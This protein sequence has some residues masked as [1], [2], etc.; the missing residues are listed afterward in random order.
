MEKLNVLCE[1]CNVGKLVVINFYKIGGHSIGCDVC[2]NRFSASQTAYNALVTESNH[3]DAEND[4]DVMNDSGYWSFVTE[5]KK[6][7]DLDDYTKDMNKIHTI[8]ENLERTYYHLDGQFFRF[9]TYH[10]GATTMH[11][12]KPNGIEEFSNLIKHFFTFKSNPLYTKQTQI[13]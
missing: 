12:L 5:Y 11:H 8:K 10:D 6:G 7:F 9:A 13:L 2:N 4:V 3:N 1:S